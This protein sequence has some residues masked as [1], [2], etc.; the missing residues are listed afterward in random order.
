MDK[1]HPLRTPMVIRSLDLNKDLFKHWQRDEELHGQEVP[2]LC[3]IGAL[4]YHDL[5]KNGEIN[6]QQTYSNDNLVNLFTKAL[7]TTMFEKLVHNIGVSRCKD[8]N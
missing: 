4:M 8:I 3:A 6:I 1:S 2:Y 7:P 5:L